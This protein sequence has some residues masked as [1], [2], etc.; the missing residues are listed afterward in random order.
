MRSPYP[1]TLVKGPWRARAEVAKASKAQSEAVALEVARSIAGSLTGED[2][3]LA[4]AATVDRLQERVVQ[5]RRA[6]RE[7]ATQ[8]AAMSFDVISLTPVAPPTRGATGRLSADEVREALKAARASGDTAATFA[9]VARAL[10]SEQGLALGGKGAFGPAPAPCA[11][12][13]RPFSGGKRNTPPAA[14]LGVRHEIDAAPF[15]PPAAPEP[16]PVQ[17]VAPVKGRAARAAPEPTPHH[18]TPPHTTPRPVNPGERQVR[19]PPRVTAE[20]I[21]RR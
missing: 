12:S 10:A 18:P 2:K 6:E 7:L 14:P 4:I 13:A 3:R 11:P 5:E 1:E 9:S 20:V 15:L 19:R 21:T 16:A 17:T 8:V